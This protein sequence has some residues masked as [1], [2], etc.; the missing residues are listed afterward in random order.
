MLNSDIA[1]LIKHKF[2]VEIKDFVINDKYFYGIN[3]TCAEDGIIV[4]KNKEFNDL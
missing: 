2:N 4:A 3:I 1:S